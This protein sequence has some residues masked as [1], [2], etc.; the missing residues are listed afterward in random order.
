MMKCTKEYRMQFDEK[1]KELVSQMTLEEKVTMM[2]GR[3]KA[4]DSFGGGSYNM[5]PY[6]FGGCERLGIPTLEFCDGPRGVVSGNS[7]CFPVSMARG[8]TFDPD[9]EREVGHVIGKEILANG[10]NYFGGVCMNIPYN[11]GAGRSQECYGEDSFHMGEMASALMEGVQEENVIAC[12]KHFAFNSMERSRFKVN[13]EADKRTEQEVYLPHFRKFVKR[14]GASVMNAYSKY[15][16]EHCGHS[17]YLLRKLLKEEMDF[18]GV[19]I[20]DFMLG[21][22]SAKQGI[23]GGCDVEMHFRW[24]YTIKKVK[25]AMKKGIITE[26]MLDEACTRIVRTTLAFEEARKGTQKPGKEILACK[27]HTKLARKVA[28]ESITLLQNTDNLLPL[29]ESK[30][31]VF[32]GDLANIENIGDHGSSMVRPPYVT[33][34]MEAMQEEYAHVHFSFVPTKEVA[35]QADLIRSADAVVIT[36][37]MKH[38]DEGEFVFVY[39]GDRESLELHADELDMIDRIAS[40]NPNTAVIVMGGNVIMTH[41]WKD[42]VK[43]I[44]FAYY[45]GMEGGGALADILFGKVNPSGKLPFAIAKNEYDY[46]QVD[47]NAKEQYYGYWHGYHKLDREK[48]DCDFAF[49]FGLSYTDFELADFHLVSNEE[50]AAV[51]AVDVTNTGSR[52]GKEVVQLYASFDSATVERP[53]RTLCSF[54]KVELQPGETKTVTLNVDKEDLAWFDKASNSFMQD[55]SY[56]AYVGTD[57]RTL[58]GEGIAF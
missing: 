19:V 57:E 51:F 41:S 36:A 1:A 12:A 9:L 45:P 33:T 34:L 8:A 23:P 29:D 7:T 32:A 22:R 43:A 55:D 3:C 17:K 25:E 46:P 10:G 58:I 2:A 24:H 40:L 56:T 13:V 5:V 26:A 52:K 42:K 27:E 53:V 4:T 54:S 11:P 30:H 28:E 6:P 39:G 38:S 37:G 48:K 47:W 21:V 18:D 31:I 35:E 50:N 15:K 16:G 14:G 44:L 20:S 49:G